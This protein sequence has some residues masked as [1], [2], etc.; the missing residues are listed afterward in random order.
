MR[1]D[2]YLALS[3]SLQATAQRRATV[4]LRIL[5]ETV[6]DAVPPSVT[7]SLARATPAGRSERRITAFPVTRDLLRPTV[8]HLEPFHM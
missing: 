3:S 6:Q 8:P 4:W 1:L 2:L 5:R 7:P